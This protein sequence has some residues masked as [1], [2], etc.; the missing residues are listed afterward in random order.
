MPNSLKYAL[1]SALYAICDLICARMAKVVMIWLDS[2]EW[3]LPVEDL[4]LASDANGISLLTTSSKIEYKAKIHQ[5]D[6]PDK[7]HSQIMN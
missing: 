5:T 1:M 2:L 3:L 6:W 4:T 7:C